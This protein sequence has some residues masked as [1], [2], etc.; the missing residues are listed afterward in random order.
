M[1][2][3]IRI[4]PVSNLALLLP[5]ANKERAMNK[6]IKYTLSGILMTAPLVTYAE[7]AVTPTV[8]APAQHQEAVPKS[9]VTPNTGK[10]LPKEEG[11]LIA[12]YYTRW[13]LWPLE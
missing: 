7:T 13:A 10:V 5:I 2:I 9:T 6:L 12:R 4:V 3:K 11:K 1:C 8:K